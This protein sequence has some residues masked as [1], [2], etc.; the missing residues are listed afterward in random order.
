[1]HISIIIRIL[2]AQTCEKI[3]SM[4]NYCFHLSERCDLQFLVSIAWSASF[5]PLFFP[6]KSNVENI[7]YFLV[8]FS[9]RPWINTSWLFSVRFSYNPQNLLEIRL[10]ILYIILHKMNKQLFQQELSKEIARVQHHTDPN[11]STC[12]DVSFKLISFRS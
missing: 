1:M 6:V 8:L 7:I 9:I 4:R 3:A 11:L 2:I 5:P 12:L 10:P